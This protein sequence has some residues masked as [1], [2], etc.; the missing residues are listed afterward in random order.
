[1]AQH[2]NETDIVMPEEI[3]PGVHC[4]G[5]GK[6]IMRSNVYFV[7]SGSSWALIDTAGPKCAASIQKAAASLFGADTRPASIL[8]THSHPDHAGSARELARAWRCP[9]YLHPDELPLTAG[10]IAVV[11]QYSNPLDRWIILPMLRIMPPRKAQAMLAQGSLA[12]VALALDP[13]AELPGLPDWRCIHTPGHT[14]GH[15]SFF[16]PRDRVLITGDAIVTVNLN[17]PSGLLL[18]KPRLSGPPWYSTWNWQ[19]AKTSAAALA[20]LEPRVLAGGH[21]APSTSPTTARDVQ[22]FAERFAT[23]S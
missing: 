19:A 11:R 23:Q 5:A 1:M 15:V 20:K 6:G 12:D 17:S 4:V 10:D 3:A 9:I 8:L 18:N 22:A 2:R 13:S 7:R 21:G 14:P 16:R